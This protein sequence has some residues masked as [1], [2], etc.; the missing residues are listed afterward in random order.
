[1]RPDF[2]A[3]DGSAAFEVKNYNIATN[4]DGLVNT[5]SQQITDRAANLPQGM[6]QQVIIDVRGQVVS[7]VQKADIVDGIVS[8][9]NSVVS[10]NSIIF[11]DF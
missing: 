4:S 2:V 3:S 10:A 7:A 6:A 9:T 1:V 8:K 11:K 5:V